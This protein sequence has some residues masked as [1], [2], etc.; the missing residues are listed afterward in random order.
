M[1]QYK[2]SYPIKLENTS[3]GFCMTPMAIMDQ[4]EQARKSALRSLRDFLK[5]E[6]LESQVRSITSPVEGGLNI[7]CSEAVAAKLKTAP[8]LSNVEDIAPLNQNKPKT[9]PFRKSSG[10]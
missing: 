2:L 5:N 10:F 4:M 1:K 3:G 7:W 8:F 6:G 9:P